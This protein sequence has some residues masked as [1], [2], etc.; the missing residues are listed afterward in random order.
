MAALIQK[1]IFL[2]MKIF[3]SIFKNKQVY[4]FD[5]KHQCPCHLVHIDQP[6]YNEKNDV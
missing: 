6:A 1:A 4:K 5:T 2:D 3:F